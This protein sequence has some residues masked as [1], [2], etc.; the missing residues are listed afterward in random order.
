ME[1]FQKQLLNFQFPSTTWDNKEN[2]E[3]IPDEDVGGLIEELYYDDD[4]IS[5]NNSMQLNFQLLPI[6]E[7]DDLISTI[8]FKGTIFYDEEVVGDTM[9]HIFEDSNTFP[10]N[11]NSHQLG[12]SNFM[13]QL[14]IDDR[15]TNEIQ[16]PFLMNNEDPFASNSMPFRPLIQ[17]QAPQMDLSINNA[18]AVLENF[19]AAV[20]QM[21]Q[22]D[23]VYYNNVFRHLA[24]S[25]EERQSQGSREEEL[26]R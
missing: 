21:P 5:N 23:R 20:N 2:N 4:L 18:E 9:Q 13:Q 10:N 26:N 11:N 8:I 19:K 12:I 7:D 3:V 15:V 25:L 14:N 16:V 22:S 17:N 6:S 24:T 1:E